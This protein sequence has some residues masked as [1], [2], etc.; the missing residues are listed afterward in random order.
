MTIATEMDLSLRSEYEAAELGDKRRADRLKEIAEAVAKSPD[1][2]FP[3]LFPDTADLEATYRFLRNEHVT[4]EA[5]L[6]PHMKNTAQRAAQARAVIVAHD[7]TEFNFGTKPRDGLGHV[8]R[9]KSYGFYG[10]AS[11]VIEHSEERLPLGLAALQIHHRTGKLKRN[12]KKPTHRQRHEDP[13]NEGARWLRGVEQAAATLT[14]CPDVIHVMD[15]EAD[16]YALF[17]AMVRQDERFVIRCNYD[18][19]TDK[20]L[21]LSER[22]AAMPVLEGT[23]EINLGRRDASPMPGNRKRYPPREERQAIVAVSAGTVTLPRPSSSTHCPERRLTLNF[24]RVFEPD[25]PKGEAAVEWRLWTTEPIDTEEQVWAVVDAYRARW[26]V[27][28][29]FKAI[30]TGCAYESRQC[31]TADSL[32]RTLALFMPIAWWLLMLRTVARADPERPASTV[33]APLQLRCLRAALRNIKVKL[34][35]KPT[36]RDALLGIARLG[37]HIPRNGE[38]GWIVLRRGLEKLSLME[39]GYRLARGREM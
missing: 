12:G 30:K 9:G 10:H 8:G 32:L 3:T 37:G 16:D 28:E 27:E 22:M 31:E 38:P 19:C 21:K 33:L 26:V 17:A 13:D 29:Y 4:P 14:D 23:R 39:E 5:I 36:V 25:P 35:D 18:R 2:S 1:A 15:R 7:T 24:V 11:L 6:A 20:R 34:P